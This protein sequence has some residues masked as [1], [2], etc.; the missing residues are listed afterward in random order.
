MTNWAKHITIDQNIMFGKPVIRDT[1]ITV[2]L[3]MDKLAEGES[4]EQILQ[5]HLEMSREDILA[6][7]AYAADSLKN[8]SI[9]PIAV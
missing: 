7:L 3:I 8:E 1:R 9:Y 2:E 4:F 6:C 5:S